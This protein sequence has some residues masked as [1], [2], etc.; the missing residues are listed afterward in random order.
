VCRRYVPLDVIPAA[1]ARALPTRSPAWFLIGG[2]AVRCFAPY[3]P[4]NDVDLGVRTK[5]DLDALV[6]ALAERTE[7]SVLERSE[8]TIHLV[9][10]G[11]DVSI[12]V[13]P[14]I[15]K[16]APEQ[17]LSADGVLATKLHAILDRGTRR[18]FF[19]LYV[20]MQ[21][22]QVGI[23]HCFHALRKV[24]GEE[25]NEGL[26]VR[27]ITFF[28]DAERE[29]R[30]AGEGASDWQRLKQFFMTAAGALIV[31]PHAALQIQRRVVDVRTRTSSR[32]RGKQTVSRRRPTRG[33]PQ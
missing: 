8:D 18:D 17:S 3:R 25:I 21:Q 2:H 11:V 23:A 4:S 14:K 20:M 19:D 13:L 24:Y 1:V 5:K 28:D 9:V 33:R 12:F 7:L 27:A 32:T 10:D 22:E 31:P 29:P 30:L 16:H 6:R 15:K 26:F